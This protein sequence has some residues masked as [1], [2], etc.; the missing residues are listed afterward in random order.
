LT[1]CR[2]LPSSRL[3]RAFPSALVLYYGRRTERRNVFQLMLG[4]PQADGPSMQAPILYIFIAL[5]D[6]GNKTLSCSRSVV[7]RRSLRVPL[8]ASSWSIHLRRLVGWTPR[9]CATLLAGLSY[10]RARRTARSR[11]SVE[12]RTP[13][14]ERQLASKVSQPNCRLQPNPFASLQNC[15]V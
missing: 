11:N 15:R 2:M 4:A 10:S 12:Y 5:D 9:S 6:E 13:I 1:M 8:S 7:V 14:P 3:G